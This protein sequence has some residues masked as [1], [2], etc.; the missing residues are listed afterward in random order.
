M[1]GPF[2][3]LT[4]EVISRIRAA[5]APAAV[6]EEEAKRE[7]FGRDGTVEAF[8]M[9]ELVVE[10]T[11]VKQIQALLRLANEL[12][13]PVTPRGLGTGLAGGAIP[14]RGGVVLSLA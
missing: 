13:F 11:E 14:V 8:A 4:K 3:P 5:V 2:T 7:V 9:P 1:P 10:A 12:R 6:L